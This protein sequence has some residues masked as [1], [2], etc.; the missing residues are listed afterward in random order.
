[1]YMY[2]K[3]FLYW[4]P[5]DEYIIFDPSKCSMDH[6]TLI[7]SIYVGEPISTLLVKEKQNYLINMSYLSHDTRK[8]LLV[9]IATLPR[10]YT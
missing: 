5:V 8:A 7:V 4:N 9:Y 2:L 10:G 3:T 1:M 6:S